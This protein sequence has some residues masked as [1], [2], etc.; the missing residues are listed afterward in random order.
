MREVSAFKW[1][2][3]Y[4]LQR[5]QAAGRAVNS[6]RDTDRAAAQWPTQ[7]STT[8]DALFVDRSQSAVRESTAASAA[9]IESISRLSSMSHTY[10][11]VAVAW[12]V[13]NFALLANHPDL[14]DVLAIS[15]AIDR[16]LCDRI[17]LDNIIYILSIDPL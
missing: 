7:L 9:P 16:S 8:S 15:G 13:R 3:S 12:T 11:C 5:V 4:S 2:T 10:C 14:I 17:S 1:L 6:V